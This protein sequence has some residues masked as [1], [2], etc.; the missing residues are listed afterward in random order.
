MGHAD[1]LRLTADPLFY[2]LPY[3]PLEQKRLHFPG[4]PLLSPARSPGSAGLSPRLGT[5]SQ[6]AAFPAQAR[7]LAGPAG[8]GS[9]WREPGPSARR[10]LISSVRIGEK[11]KKK[12][13]GKPD[14][15][16]QLSQRLESGRNFPKNLAGWKV[17]LKEGNPHP[18]NEAK[19]V[20]V[21]GQVYRRNSRGEVVDRE[22]WISA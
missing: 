11:K 6:A 19:A 12:R 10:F 13:S 14:L 3:L 17:R 15:T 9:D 2:L 1:G 4:N 16:L 8:A 5:A 20:T 22:T 18:R 21:R 7:G